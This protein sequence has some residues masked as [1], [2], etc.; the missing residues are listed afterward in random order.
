MSHILSG[1]SRA[2]TTLNYSTSRNGLDILLPKVYTETAK[3]G[4]Y[5]FGAQVFNNLPSCLKEPKSLL[6]FKTMLKDF[7]CD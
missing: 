3:K 5:Y 1:I 2:P 7:L 6:I 4:C